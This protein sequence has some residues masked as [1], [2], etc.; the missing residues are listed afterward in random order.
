MLD[1]GLLLVTGPRKVN[2]VLLKRTMQTMTIA[3]SA[4]ADV[5]GVDVSKI[6][7]S[8]FKR[9]KPAK[10]RTGQKASEREWYNDGY[11]KVKP[12]QDQIEMQEAVDKAVKWTDPLMKKYLKCAFALS[13]KSVPHNMKF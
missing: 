9:G 13:K 10:L 4:K 7:D 5:S 2:G 1:S 3:T 12:E 6:D 8:Y 11:K